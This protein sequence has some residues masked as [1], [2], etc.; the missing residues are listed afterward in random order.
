M[1]AKKNLPVRS[2]QSGDTVQGFALLTKKELRQDKNGKSFLDLEVSD[3]TGSMAAKI[4]ADSPAMQSQFEVHRFIAFR[5]LVKLYKDQLQ[6]SIDECR[7]TTD[8]DHKHGFDESLL[9]PSTRE[10]IGDLW[11][12]LTGL[13]TE[14][15]ER[16]VL[17]RLAAETMEIYGA[18]LREH[19]AAKT[20]H[21]AYRGGLL[22]HV[23]SMAEFAVAVAGHFK[24]LDRDLLLVGVLF[25]DLGKLYELGAMPA[26]D[27]TLVGRLVG[28]VV[29]GRD[30][31]RDRC[32]AI[33]EFP[34]DL[35]LQLEHLVLSHQGKKEYASPVEPMTVEAVALHFIDDLDSKLNQLRNAREN[36]PGLPFLRGL[37]RHMYLPGP[38]PEPNAAPEIPAPIPSSPPAPAA[39]EPKRNGPPPS[40]RRETPTTLASL[41]AIL[42]PRLAEIKPSEPTEA[43]TPEPR[44]LFDLG[45]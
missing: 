36:Q 39:H 24:E 27:Y 41:G 2:W 28:H 43:K 40:S 10:D 25:H 12:R 33:P 45:E 9:I 44:S 29:I 23:V 6:L 21:H 3:A 35:Q 5:G 31:L 15:V 13:M 19:P 1:A 34:S 38:P 4:W 37:G 22:E 7:E 30:L 14:Q 42:G 18:A 16:P 11:R 32:A 26:N 20:M 17:R 8:E